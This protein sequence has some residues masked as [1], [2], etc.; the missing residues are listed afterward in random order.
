MRASDGTTTPA[1]TYAAVEVVADEPPTVEIEPLADP[2]GETSLNRRESPNANERFVIEGRA[3]VPAISYSIAGT[4]RTVYEAASTATSL[5]YEW[6][7]SPWL[8][9]SSPLVAQQIRDASA[10]DTARLILLPHALVPGATYRFELHATFEGETGFAAV[11]VVVNRPPWGGELTLWPDFNAERPAVA[12]QA[13]TLRA[14]CWQDSSPT[15]R[16]LPPPGYGSSVPLVP[17]PRW[18]SGSR[19]GR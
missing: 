13:V 18:A 4:D 6:V 9:L 14:R 2:F 12:L 3:S 8:N 1:I 17:P 19:A 15:L 5:R 10:E 7:A 11:D 16:V